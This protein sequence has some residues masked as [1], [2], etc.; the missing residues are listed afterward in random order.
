MSPVGVASGVTVSGCYSNELV[1]TTATRGTAVGGS[2]GV[3]GLQP[4]AANG[5]EV[6]NSGAVPT[7]GGLDIWWATVAVGS[8][9]ARVAAE[10]PDGATDAMRPQDGIA[11]LGGLTP[12]AVTSRFFSVVAEDA[13]GQS[14][15]SIGFLAGW[16]P[17]AIGTLPGPSSP[18]AST[19]CASAAG[20]GT[21]DES[22]TTL[23]GSQPAAPLLATASVVSAFHQAYA[24]GSPAGLAVSLS[25]V[26]GGTSLESPG[27]QRSASAGS[28]RA[29]VSPESA[30][31]NV[32]VARVT[33]LSARE[34]EVIYRAGGGRWRTG[35]AFV[36][37]SGLWDVSRTTFCDDVLT[38]LHATGLIPATVVADCQQL[39]STG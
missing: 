8:Q 11:V 27:G 2:T 3:V 4:L 26:E 23:H 15:H 21:P 34:A 6:V 17:E 22:A 20:A 16:G 28:G 13:T 38:G 19:S 37:R 9:V 36:T 31:G 35:I 18:V 29:G 5:L 12:T 32:E 10:E 39:A 33:F 24:F 30:A 14:L 7:S 1:T 25:A